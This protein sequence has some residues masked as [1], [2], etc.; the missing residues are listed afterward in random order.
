VGTV[1]G[2][3]SDATFGLTLSDTDAAA[4]SVKVNT[5]GGDGRV[6]LSGITAAGLKRLVAKA[7]DL[8]GDAAFSGPPGALTLG[9]VTGSAQAQ[10]LLSI[11]GSAG[12]PVTITLGRVSDLSVESVAPLKA[13]VVTDWGHDAGNVTPDRIAAPRLASLKA[14]GS[15]ADAVQ[16]DA[17]V[18]KSCCSATSG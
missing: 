18:E 9:D 13:L 8:Q 15:R 17:S 12:A 6:V 14:A 5:R 10:R 16:G 7:A 1:S 11:G 3:D 2:A 4:T